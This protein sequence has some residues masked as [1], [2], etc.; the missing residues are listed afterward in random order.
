MD[1]MNLLGLGGLNLSYFG[2]IGGGGLLEQLLAMK[3][4]KEMLGEEGETPAQKPKESDRLTGNR[5]DLDESGKYK[6]GSDGILIFD[7]DNNGVSEED[8][9]KSK[10]LLNYLDD[11]EDGEIPEEL[12]KMD[13]N[14]DGK[15]DEGELKAA[16]AQVW[17]DRNKD[18]KYDRGE[19]FEVGEDT[20]VSNAGKFKL[21]SYNLR[22][23]AIKA[24]ADLGVE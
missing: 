16:H 13:K 24:E 14:G 8:I 12:K 20:I 3:L 4:L 9:S 10:K 11:G 21:R 18:G 15:L 17:V 22:T 2:G 5:I 23:G 7:L 19:R 1:W 6:S